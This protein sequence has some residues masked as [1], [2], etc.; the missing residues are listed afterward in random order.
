MKDAAKRGERSIRVFKYDLDEDMTIATLRSYLDD[1]YTLMECF[2][3]QGRS[4][5]N[6]MP[7]GSFRHDRCEEDDSADCE[8]CKSGWIWYEIS[9]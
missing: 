1:G 6:R 2:R 5:T 4:Y 8:A 9:W 7:W 3:R